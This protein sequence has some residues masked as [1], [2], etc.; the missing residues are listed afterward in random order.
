[1]KRIPFLVKLSTLGRLALVGT[2]SVLALTLP[3]RAAA[4]DSLTAGDSALTGELVD[5]SDDTANFDIAGTDSSVA[6]A[7]DDLKNLTTDKPR[8]II[9][10]DDEK[11]DGNVE[12]I[13]D[14]KLMIRTTEGRE[15][16][17]PLTEV[18]SLGGPAASALDQWT[19][20]NL[21]FWS[22]SLDLSASTSQATT[23][24]TQ[25]LFGASA[26]RTSEKSLLNIGASYRYGT[27]KADQEPTQTNL[28]EAIGTINIRYT[29][30]EEI[31]VFGDMAATYNAIQLL[32]LRAQPS[33]G[34]G[35]D[36]L[37]NGDGRLS[38]KAGFGWVFERYFGGDENKYAALALGLDSEWKLPL[39]SKVTAELNYLPALNAFA[40]NYLLQARLSYT[41]PVISFL[42]FKVQLTDDYNNQPAAGTQPN[43]F[44]F[45]V[46]LSVTL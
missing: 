45:N 46:G 39:D 41:I 22:G 8:L 16:Q 29:V 24:T 13:T 21:R 9:Y 5:I 33:A 11:I 32:S 26:R 2:L 44:Y 31:F 12:G 35:W 4:M 14:G 1:M 23:D 3:T 20:D 42:N 27:Q 18:I 6:V 36:I 15:I 40:D 30:W 38:A 10:G 37:N 17:V 7:T 43:S 19:R 28:D 34:V 25:I